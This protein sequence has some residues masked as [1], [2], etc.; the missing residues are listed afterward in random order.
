MKKN[1]APDRMAAESVK[2]HSQ[3][4]MEQRF[5]GTSNPRHIRALRALL[6]KSLLRDELDDIAGCSNGPEL[7]SQLRH[8][9][10]AL[11][12]ERIERIDRDG[13]VCRPGVYSLTHSDRICVFHWLKMRKRGMRC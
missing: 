3:S 6:V 1:N 4:S 2:M 5:R 12:C 10:L 9:G 8:L 7:V 13:R 11:P